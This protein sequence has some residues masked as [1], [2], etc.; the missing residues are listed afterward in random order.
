MGRHRA[1]ILSILLF[2]FF[3]LV[4]AQSPVALKGAGATLPV[5]ILSTGTPL[6]PSW[7][8]SFQTLTAGLVNTNYNPVGSGL[9][10]Q[11]ILG[12]QVDFAISSCALSNAELMLVNGKCIVNP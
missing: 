3:G 11:Q 5:S 12:Q 4:A 2:V 8:N 7:I 10:K 1:V 6:T 9:G